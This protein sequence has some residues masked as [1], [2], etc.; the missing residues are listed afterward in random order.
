MQYIKK[1]LKVLIYPIIFFIIQFLLEFIFVFIF[2]QTEIHKLKIKYPNYSNNQIN[3]KL[4]EIIS[5]S[6]YKYRLSNYLN[7]NALLISIVLAI[8]L[9]P[10]FV[11]TYKKIIKEKSAEKNIKLNNII[12]FILIGIS[13]S[14]IYNITMFNVNS[15]IKI[16]D[17][18]K[19][20]NIPIL[21][22]ILS[23]GLI[24]PIL[25]ELVFRGIVYNKLKKINKTMNSIIISSIIFSLFHFSSILN[26]IYSFMMSF[27]FIYAYEKSRSIIGSIVLHCSANITIILFMY[28]L[29]N[30]VFLINMLVFIICLVVLIIVYIR[31]IRKDASIYK[32]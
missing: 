12:I 3:N 29:I 21:I 4:S 14:L 16:T 18:Y 26:L 11:V 30:N 1:I 28:V 20:S 24:G 6:S 7:H 5:T 2:N 9:I 31:I 8:I 23:S 15:I 27:L 10:I 17:S 32:N 19:I 13:V 22:Q 25:E